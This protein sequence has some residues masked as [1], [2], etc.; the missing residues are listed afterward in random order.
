METKSKTKED[1]K[2]EQ[3]AAEYQ[4]MKQ[5]KAKHFNDLTFEEKN[6]IKTYDRKIANEKVKRSYKLI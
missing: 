2:A 1:L 5:L 3:A 4:L 6:M